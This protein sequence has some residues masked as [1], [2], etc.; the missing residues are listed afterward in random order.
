[1]SDSLI[2]KE[3]AKFDQGAAQQFKRILALEPNQLVIWFG[4]LTIIDTACP[5]LS[6]PIGGSLLLARLSQFGGLPIIA[7]ARS[8]VSFSAIA[9][10]HSKADMIISSPFGFGLHEKLALVQSEQKTCAELVDT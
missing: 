9:R 5:S 1:V 7:R 3:R 6:D 8:K 10:N 2:A 4:Y